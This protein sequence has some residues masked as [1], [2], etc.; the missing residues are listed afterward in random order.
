MNLL[1]TSQSIGFLTASLLITMTPGPDNLLVLSLG[2][3]RGRRQGM[4]FGWGC[5]MGCL[6]H[7]VLAALGISA[8]VAASPWAFAALKVAGGAYLMYLGWQALRHAGQSAAQI[9]SG[10]PESLSRLFAKGLVANAVNPKVVLFFLAFLPQFVDTARG[11]TPWQI[12]QLGVI[13]TLQAALLFGVLGYFAGSI[14]Q[15]LGRHGKAGLW[16][17]R[18]AGTVFVVLGLKL[19][20]GR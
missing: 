5:A 19:I 6:S 7:T 15:W 4:V 16:L 20:A 1:A 10:L 11:D 18:V 9:G 3:S 17:D 8:L 14:G 13:F 12:V 2:A